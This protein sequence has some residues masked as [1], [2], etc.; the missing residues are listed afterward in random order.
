MKPRPDHLE[1]VEANAE[2]KTQLD[3]PQR[4][5]AVLAGEDSNARVQALEAGEREIEDLLERHR[6]ELRSA[7]VADGERRLAEATE[8]FAAER[9]ELERLVAETRSVAEEWVEGVRESHAQQAQILFGERVGREEVERSLTEREAELAQAQGELE[10]LRAEL[11]RERERFREF[12]QHAAVAKSQSEETVA[13][14]RSEAEAWVVRVREHYQQLAEQ[15]RTKAD[16]A[17]ADAR[18]DADRANLRREELEQ[19]LA[20]LA[21]LDPGQIPK[22][23]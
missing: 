14:A 23:D 9:S 15:E 17:L 18:A 22:R 11:D 19:R 6:Q 8:R 7:L 10:H 12:E 4:D 5:P 3:W 2:D 1:A 13:A 16:D 20:E 21:G